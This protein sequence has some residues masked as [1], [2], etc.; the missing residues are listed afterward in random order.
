MFLREQ[1]GLE[2]AGAAGGRSFGRALVPIAERPWTERLR[3]AALQTDWVPDLGQRIG[4]RDWWRG[5][6][7]C[8]ALCG[9]AWMLSPG[10]RPILGYAAPAIGGAAFEET[11]TQGIAPLAYGATTGRRMAAGSLVRQ[12]K[13]TPERPTI[14]LT[15]ALADGDTLPQALQRAGIG[16]NEAATVANLVS[17]AVR[18]DSL[19]PGT[20]LSLT[21]GRRPTKLQPRP[22][23]HLA[24]RA[25][26]DLELAVTRTG[27]A[28]SL[29]R[30]PIAIDRTPLRVR[31]V[32]GPS[33]YRSARAA[34]VPARLVEAYIRA[35]ATRIPIADVAASD[36][37]DLV[38]DQRRA[39]TGEVETGALQFAGL[40]QGGRRLQLVRWDGRNPDGDGGSFWDANGRYETRGTMG[41]PVAGRV[42]S[43]F[44]MR[45]HPLLGFMRMHKG[46]D[47][48]APHGAPI[49]AAVDGV[50]AF[51]GRSGGYGN[52]IK[53][54]HPGGLASGYGH[55]SRF[56]VRA[57]QRVRRGQV[58]GYVG[59]TGISTGPHLHWEVWKNGRPV[60]PRSISLASIQTLSGDTLRAMR[61]KIAR[62]LSTPAR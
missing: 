49:L 18:V 4:T 26:F 33:L 31:G 62:L 8:T 34:G 3:V 28:L 48:G 12:L 35:L 37:F 7:T 22:L 15:A 24:F 16:R 50:V 20:V 54:A 39:A 2:L 38:A 47:I 9:A 45:L 19:K 43:T 30:R 25:A 57:G 55:M 58:I 51:A 36:T 32:V 11:R 40:D 41:M 46:M 27:D 10:W 53:L 44:G 52:F 1:Q 59:S 29:D 13:E 56:A 61:A 60:N 17:G 6:A 42:T 14:E 21:L 23:D 5:L